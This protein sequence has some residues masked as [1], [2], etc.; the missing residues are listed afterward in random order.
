MNVITAT[1]KPVTIEA[2]VW[3]GYNLNQVIKFTGQNVSVRD[4]SWGEYE[5]LVSREGL[6]IFTLEGSHMASV[7]DYIIKG[8]K[9]EFYPCKPD[10]FEM[11]YDIN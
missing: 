10:I 8:V 4:L 7:G 5:E 3:T 2:I 11:T 9:G 6:K 1:K